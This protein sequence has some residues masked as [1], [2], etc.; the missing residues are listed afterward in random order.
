VW[1]ALSIQA[2]EGKADEAVPQVRGQAVRPK[3]EFID[4]CNRNELP[5]ETQL[6]WLLE[7]VEDHHNSLAEH[8]KRK[9]AKDPSRKEKA[10]ETPEFDFIRWVRRVLDE[11]SW[12]PDTPQDIRHALQVYDAEVGNNAYVLCIM[13]NEAAM[14]EDAHLVSKAGKGVWV[15]HRC[16]WEPYQEGLR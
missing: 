9:L 10:S 13:C 2:A 5:V 4:I 7:W 6:E 8:T 16:C 3:Q 1:P 12:S 11:P 15:G 14:A